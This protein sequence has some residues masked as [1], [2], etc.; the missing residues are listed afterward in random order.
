MD[1]KKDYFP[2]PE[3]PVFLLNKGPV[4]IKKNAK[5]EKKQKAAVETEAPVSSKPEPHF[6][7]NS[8]TDVASVIEDFRIVS[9]VNAP[10]RAPPNAMS[11]EDLNEWIDDKRFELEASELVFLALE[12]YNE[13]YTK[14]KPIPIHHFLVLYLF[15]GFCPFDKFTA[16]IAVFKRDFK[17]YAPENPSFDDLFS[18]IPADLPSLPRDYFN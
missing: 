7:I 6:H 18:D 13:Y 2:I 11:K 4:T 5:M 16:A 8:T 17:E 3:A 1:T 10:N 15:R 12:A 14:A 9:L